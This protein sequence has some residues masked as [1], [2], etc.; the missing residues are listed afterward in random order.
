MKTLELSYFQLALLEFERCIK[1]AYHNG[2]ETRP[3]EKKHL[4]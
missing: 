4:S 2:E 1:V 3:P